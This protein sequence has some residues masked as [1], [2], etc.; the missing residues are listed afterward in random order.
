MYL[1]VSCTTHVSKLA[2]PDVVQGVV[3]TQQRLYYLASKIPALFAYSLYWDDTKAANT[4]EL[5]K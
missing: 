1:V 3:Q 5:V 4:H 2:I